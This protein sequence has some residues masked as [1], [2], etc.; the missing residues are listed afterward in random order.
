MQKHSDRIFLGADMKYLAICLG[1]YKQL[2]HIFGAN[3]QLK[4]D[5]I[6]PYPAAL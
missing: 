1:I 4:T 3:V 2:T 5:M 6:H